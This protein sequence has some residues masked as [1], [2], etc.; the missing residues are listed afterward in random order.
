MWEKIRLLTADAEHKGW[1]MC[2]VSHWYCHVQPS[3]WPPQHALSGE[4]SYPSSI[5][6]ES[7]TASFSL[8]LGLRF[9]NGRKPQI[10]CISRVSLPGD[11]TGSTL[12]KKKTDLF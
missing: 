2:S 8:W 10:D 5:N 9:V 12:K 4:V 1:L 7:V 6:P 11:L 3:A